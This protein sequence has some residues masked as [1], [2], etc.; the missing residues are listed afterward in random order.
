MRGAGGADTL[1]QAPSQHGG[2]IRRDHRQQGTEN[3]QDEPNIDGRLA[4]N[5]IRQGTI[6]QLSNRQSD[7]QQRH[8]Q[9]NVVGRC[10]LEIL[11]H[12]RKGGQHGINTQGYQRH[13]E[14]H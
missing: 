9:L 3:E 2:K 4:P 7:E 11:R 10:H 1:Q 8:D 12:V 5:G 14:R 6:K 13:G